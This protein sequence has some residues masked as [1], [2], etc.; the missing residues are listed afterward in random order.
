MNDNFN[1]LRTIYRQKVVSMIPHNSKG[2]KNTLPDNF[3]LG[4]TDEPALP[5]LD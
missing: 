5:D 2:H 1:S 4:M 3:M